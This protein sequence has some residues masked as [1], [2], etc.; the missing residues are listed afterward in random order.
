MIVYALLVGGIAGLGAIAFRL[1]I[2]LFHNLL[3]F[4]R[5]DF[6][7]DTLL[8]ASE[9]TWG[10]GIIAVPVVGALLVAFLV[11]TFAPEARG[12][13]VSEVI[14]AINYDQG[15]IRPKVAIIKA[16]AS[17]ISIGSGGSVGR[18]GP[19][20]QIGATFGSVMAQ[21]MH[22][23]V[24]GVLSWADISEAANLPY[25]MRPVKDVR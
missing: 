25:N 8:H 7:Y 10:I 6:E 16:L 14:D 5:W 2:A 19:I 23:S 21:W 12:P 15:I 24:A 20:I 4:G 3:F 22:L 1:L 11:K 18:E 13:G 9:S 17:S